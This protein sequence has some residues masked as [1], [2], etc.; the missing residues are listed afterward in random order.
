MISMLICALIV[1]VMIAISPIFLNVIQTHFMNDLG[2]LL[3]FFGHSSF[4]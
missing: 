3:V 2:N 1:E 4:N